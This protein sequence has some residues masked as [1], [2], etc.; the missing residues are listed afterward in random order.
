ML[1]TTVYAASETATETVLLTQSSDSNSPPP[2]APSKPPI[3]TGKLEYPQN[4]IHRGAEGM[5][6]LTLDINDHG[7]VSHVVVTT[8]S[9]HADLDEAGIKFLET[10]TF[11]VP[12]DMKAG[13]KLQKDL[14]FAWKLDDVRSP[15]RKN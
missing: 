6:I 3:C 7:K 5:T 12:T 10:C 14:Q 9:G 8:S 15:D 13:T 2:T 4:A 11:Y 1:F